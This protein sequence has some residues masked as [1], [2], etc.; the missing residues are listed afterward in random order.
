[1][2]CM[3]QRVP[4]CSC[5][6]MR[7]CL[8]NA[9][10]SSK[11]HGATAH[12]YEQQRKRCKRRKKARTDAVPML[13]LTLGLPPLR[14]RMPKARDSM[15]VKSPGLPWK[16]IAPLGWTAAQRAAL[17]EGPSAM[18][19]G[20]Q[21]MSSCRACGLSRFWWSARDRLRTASSRTHL[22]DSRQESVLNA[23]SWPAV[24][25]ECRQNPNEASRR[26]PSNFAHTLRRVKLV[27]QSSDAQHA[28]RF[29][30]FRV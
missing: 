25:M 1:M 4:E 24:C 7:S 28:R 10:P 12:T 21:H 26:M 19:D 30:G 16:E 6:Q 14:L 15:F 3:Q 27:I 29:L 9:G 11:W 2:Q 17:P 20:A 5:H 13:T 23:R 18:Q 8:A 22:G